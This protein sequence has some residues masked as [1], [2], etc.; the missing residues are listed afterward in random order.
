MGGEIDDTDTHAVSM[1]HVGSSGFGAC[2]GTLI[3]PN[4]V[5]TAQHCVAQ[6]SGDG[7]VDCA[8]T[9]F[10]P[11][12]QP[13]ELYITTAT[14][15]ATTA[16]F[17]TA[18]EI[19][20]VGG[21]NFCG[22]DVAVVILSD[23]VPPEEAQWATPRVDEQ[24][25]ANEEYYAIGHGNTSDNADQGG[26]PTRHRR[27][28]LY[29]Q[30]VGEECGY[31]SGVFPSEWRGD[32]GICSGDSG[33]GSYDLAN[34]VH[35][36]ASRGAQGCASPVYGG[37]FTWAEWLKEITVYAAGTAGIDPPPWATGF[38]TDPMFNHP[39]GAE[40]R[41]TED[42]PSGACLGGYCTRPCNEAAICPED[43]ECNAELWC[44]QIPEPVEATPGQDLVVSN[45]CSISAPTEDPT[46]PIPWETLPFALGAALL[47]RRRRA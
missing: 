14:T 37:V 34:R 11:T 12:F 25:T 36:V 19:R 8:S 46:N 18:K 40:C 6:T 31:L 16:K 44:Q 35:G 26:A 4:V 47:I 9:T 45:G 20:V 17:H 28:G 41:A 23:L 15:L 32:A 42:C 22:N 1:A 21:P 2:S 13:G 30:C 24:L 39:V 43:Y 27:D 5:L 29:T 10:S 33:G 7:S 3:S 38:P